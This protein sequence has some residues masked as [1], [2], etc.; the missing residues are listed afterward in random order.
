MTV[1]EKVIA[2]VRAILIA[3][4]TINGMVQTNVYASHISSITKP[5]YPAISLHPLAGLAD[6]DAMSMVT[7]NLQID[8]WFPTQQFDRSSIEKLQDRLRTLLH[9]QTISN[10]SI[11]VSGNGWEKSIGPII[12]E[13]DTELI[14][15]PVIYTFMAF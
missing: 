13:D 7:V 12:V 2:S 1:E 6:F 9:R 15:L 8:G 5:V 10:P 11:P 14:H 4:S 3:D